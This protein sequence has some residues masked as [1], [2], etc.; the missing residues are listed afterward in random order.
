MKHYAKHPQSYY[1]HEVVYATFC[2]SVKG[3]KGRQLQGR[4]QKKHTEEIKGRRKR[5]KA[6]NFRSNQALH[7]SCKE[8]KWNRWWQQININEPEKCKKNEETQV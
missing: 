5:Q 3:V 8:N 1:C 6:T 2:G 4:R 7:A